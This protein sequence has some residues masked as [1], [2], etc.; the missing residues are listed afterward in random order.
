MRS[1]KQETGLTV[2]QSKQGGTAVKSS[3]PQTGP[4]L[5]LSVSSISLQWKPSCCCH[6]EPQP[7][8]DLILPPSLCGQQQLVLPGQGVQPIP[9]QER[10]PSCIRWLPLQTRGRQHACGVCWTK[11]RLSCPQDSH[12]W[13][14]VSYNTYM[15]RGLFFFFFFTLFVFL[16][17]SLKL[18]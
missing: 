5:T 6:H 16:E 10:C 3:K 18:F 9:H 13:S 15:D 4:C 7:R 1:I 11:D 8:E 12:G 14:W 2:R 17:L